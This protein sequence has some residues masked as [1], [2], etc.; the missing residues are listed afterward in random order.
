MKFILDDE[1]ITLKGIPQKKIKVIEGQPSDKMIRTA[2]HCCLLQVRKIPS[3]MTMEGK[4]TSNQE[5]QEL[6]QLK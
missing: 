6:Q 3:L 4:Q 1:Q 2:D 5:A